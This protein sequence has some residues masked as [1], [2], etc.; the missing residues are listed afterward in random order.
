MH[1]TKLS[2]ES[3]GNAL[4]PA[5]LI[6]NPGEKYSPQS[7]Q[8]QGI[9]GI[10][11][12]AT[13][14]LWATWYS[15]GAGEGPDNY[16]LLVS[17]DDDGKS[18]S[19]PSLV[20]DP[21]GQVRAFDP[22]LWMDPSQCLWLFWAQSEGLFDGR[23]GVWA[24]CQDTSNSWSAPRRLCD[25]IMMNKPIVL[26]SGEWMLPVA[27]WGHRQIEHPAVEPEARTPHV[28]VS[29]DEGRT[30]TRRGGV[31]MA[32]RGCDEHMIVERHDGSLWMLTRL[33]DGIGE[34]TSHDKG[35]TWS[36]GRKTDL[37]HPSTRF[38]IRRLSSGHLLLVK[39]HDYTGRSHLTAFLSTDDGETWQGGLLLDERA[40]VSY[41][42]GAQTADGRIYIIYD[43][44]RYDA[45]EIL[46]AVFSEADV[47][48]RTA[49]SSDMR[50]K[51]QNL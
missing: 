50:L 10:E 22:V 30:W 33:L 16:V 43:R 1:Q 21:P 7:R 28:V 15:G 8:W 36:P 13:G 19:C 37:Q 23:A 38:F 3:K 42:D 40:N 14:R 26:I 32:N 48:M 2:E 25:G 12:D 27:I 41:P 46:M 29:S 5:E 31:E 39:H 44:E 9:P 6:I 47:L 34:S 49:I 11:I 45:K 17:S 18:W 51:V 20:I 24:I 35:Y 4:Q